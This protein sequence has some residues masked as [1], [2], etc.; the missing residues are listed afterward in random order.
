VSKGEITRQKV[1][2]HALGMATT[3]GL[4]GLT[5]GG[6]ADDLGLSKSGL[7]AHFR[8]KEALQVQ[9]VEHAAAQF[10]ELVV[11]PALKAPRGEARVRA[12]FENWIR[13]PERSSLPGGCFFVAVA[14]E[15]DD[16]PGLAHDLLVRH[17]KD[18]LDI[19]ANVVRTAV[20]EG[21]FKKSADP[22]QLAFEMYGL[23]LVCH[24]YTRLLGDPRA[25]S[26]A[27]HAF[28]ALVAR[29]KA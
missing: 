14:T 11:K 12:V 15:M 28:E 16:R 2:D 8:S 18:W 23:M 29:V 25:V 20:A 22:E 13:W 6:L 5:I 4:E 7:F 10:T 19:I 21:H 24:H 26:R 9:V 17:Q 1:L 3:V 27:K